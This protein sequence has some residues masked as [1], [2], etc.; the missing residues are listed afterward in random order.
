[1][2]RVILAAAMAGVLVL[3]SLAL[4][5]ALPFFGGTAESQSASTS[6]SDGFGGF[7]LIGAP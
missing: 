7:S 4:T 5:G 6:P 1:M 3:V 2:K